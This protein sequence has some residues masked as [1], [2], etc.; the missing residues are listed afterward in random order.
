MDDDF[1]N[2]FTDNT[3]SAVGYNIRRLREDH[4]WTAQMLADAMAFRA[5]GRERVTADDI[6]NWENGMPTDVLTILLVAEVLGAPLSTLFAAEP[7]AEAPGFTLF[8]CGPDP[9]LTDSGVHELAQHARHALHDQR[10][11]D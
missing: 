10:S 2:L 11:D 5:G 8:A 1:G 6:T 7:G 3:A 4:R 9:H